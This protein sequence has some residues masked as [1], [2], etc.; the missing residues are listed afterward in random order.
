MILKN[1]KPVKTAKELYQWPTL[2]MYSTL[3]HFVF[4]RNV[5]RGHVP[6]ALQSDHKLP[7]QAHVG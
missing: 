4:Q 2:F 3:V 7:G 5:E 6:L 1:V